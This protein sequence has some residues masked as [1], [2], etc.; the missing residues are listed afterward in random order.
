MTTL[1]AQIQSALQALYERPWVVGVSGG[2]D[3]M[4]LYDGLKK[5]FPLKQL[6]IVH[7]NHQISEQASQWEAFVQTQANNH[8]DIFYGHK[9]QC[10]PPSEVI[11]RERRYEVFDRLLETLPESVLIL[12]HHQDDQTETILWR[13]LRGSPLQGLLGMRPSIVYHQTFL[14]VRP[15][16]AISKHTIL[17]YAQTHQI[18]YCQ[19]PSNNDPSYTR[20]NLR[21]NVL[22][23][24]PQPTAILKTHQ[25]LSYNHHT[26]EAFLWPWIESPTHIDYKNY[27]HKTLE[28]LWSLISFWIAKWQIPHPSSGALRDFCA[29]ILKRNRARLELRPTWVLCY[30]NGVIEKRAAMYFQSL[31]TEEA[32]TIEANGTIQGTWGSFQWALKTP[33]ST[34]WILTIRKLKAKERVCLNGRNVSAEALWK[35]RDVPGW[36]R[37]FYPAFIDN[38]GRCLAYGHSEN[39]IHLS[40]LEP[41][42]SIAQ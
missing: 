27:P 13:F 21:L 10:T 41:F 19:D 40:T 6:H 18:A 30:E 4:V 11:A 37:P 34:S 23:V 17:E 33:R 20:N 14:L 15:L 8:Q 35:S 26:L 29:Q 1:K 22:P 38:E 39:G 5:T 36:K 24:L 9:V 42:Q 32:I 3:S 7:V 28:S 25:M 2:M 31:P 16:L 12:A